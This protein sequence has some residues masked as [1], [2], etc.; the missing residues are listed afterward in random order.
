MTKE[1]RSRPIGDRR[2]VKGPIPPAWANQTAVIIA[3]GPSLTIGQV[4]TVKQ[5]WSCGRCRV[6]VVNR[7]YELAPWA[8]AMY[9]ADWKFWDVYIEEIRKTNIDLMFSVDEV[10]C[11][12]YGLWY[13]ASAHKAGTQNWHSKTGLAYDPKEI[14]CGL[15]SGFQSLNV[16][17][18]LIGRRGKIVLL[19][20]DC[21]N[22]GKHFHAPHEAM[23]NAHNPEQWAAVYANAAPEIERRGIQVVNSTADT[24]I[25]C[26]DK[27]PIGAALR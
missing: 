22:E 21:K 1:P 23:N 10:P 6:M 7:A 14:H 9:A 15:H 17:V 12:K 3:S 18:H 16:V 19:G 26:F 20:F 11:K 27:M 25:E 4:N 8:D 13:I 5:E 2:F 24:S